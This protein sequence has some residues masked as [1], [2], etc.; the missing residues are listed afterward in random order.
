MASKLRWWHA[1]VAAVLVAGAGVGSGLAARH[2]SETDRERA[3]RAVSASAPSSSTT[4]TTAAVT[5]TSAGSSASTV[6]APAGASP[7]SAVSHASKN[8]SRGIEL[9]EFA[10]DSKPG[11][12]FRA[13]AT[14]ENTTSRSRNVVFHVD[15]F[16]GDAKAGVVK[17]SVDGLEPHKALAISLS[18]SDPHVDGVD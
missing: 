5:A 15:L 8:E 1:V 2:A 14:I 12:T 7:T 10:V 17:G 4:V 16:R 9:R 6:A 13:A 3:T 11:E 18:S